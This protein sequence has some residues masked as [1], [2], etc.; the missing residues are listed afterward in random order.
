MLVERPEKLVAWLDRHP[1]AQL[2]TTSVT[3]FEVR[4]GL[5]R[6]AL[7]RRRATLESQFEAIIVEDLESRV[8][9]FDAAA[10]ETAA[11]IAFANRVA[12]QTVEIRDV[13]IAS[14]ASAKGATVATRNV[15]H[16]GRMCPTVNPWDD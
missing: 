2:W 14:I 1:R 15:K 5:L 11:E 10:A 16:F 8:L 4:F 6:M 13:L 7:G 3:V 9:A 12:G